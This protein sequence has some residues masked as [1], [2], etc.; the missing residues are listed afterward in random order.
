VLQLQ[1]V[2][3][4]ALLRNVFFLAARFPAQIV[5]YNKMVGQLQDAGNTTTI[6][7][8]IDLLE[9]AFLLSGLESTVKLKRAS[10]PKLILWNNALVSAINQYSF[11]EALTERSWLGRLV[12][13]AVGAH[14]VASLQQ[15]D[16]SLS[17][18]REK[19]AEID[20]CVQFGSKR[21]AI[22]VKSG[23]ID[24]FSGL[25]QFKKRYPNS[26]LLIVG[27]GGLPLEEFFESDLQKLF[28]EL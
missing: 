27:S 25:A 15:V 6:A 19:D 4:P 9:L 28:T 14:L 12:E 16:Y 3:K 11:A 2:N 7:H 20:F 22:E 13:N 24:K 23:R 5:A 26:K 10:S 21:I 8:Y 18:W 1:V 17:Y